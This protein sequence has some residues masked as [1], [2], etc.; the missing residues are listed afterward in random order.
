MKLKVSVMTPDGIV[1]K[2]DDVD[3][4]VLPTS[5]GQI[6]ILPNH[7]SLV[8]GIEIGVLRIRVDDAWAPFI[9]FGGAAAIGKNNLQILLTTIE[10]VPSLEIEEAKTQLSFFRDEAKKAITSKEKLTAHQNLK[11]SL[12]T[13]QAINFINSTKQK[14]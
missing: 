5:T 10:E 9:A 3:E 7:A 11:K 8:T 14:S 4:V 12:A 13:F 1:L 2:R 6:G